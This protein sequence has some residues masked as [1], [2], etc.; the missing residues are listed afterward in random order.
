MRLSAQAPL[1]VDVAATRCAQLASQLDQRAEA[2]PDAQDGLGLAQHG[3]RHA[4]L[5]ER[6]V[7][8]G[9]L[10]AGLDGQPRAAP[11]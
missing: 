5:S 2:R 11:G 4:G 3:S 10:E 8:A 1:G 7:D 6:E 9:E